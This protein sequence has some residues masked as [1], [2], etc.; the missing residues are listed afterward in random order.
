ME[1]K[2][3]A[4]R[5]AETM[6]SAL[7]K[8]MA[9]NI[10][11]KD[12]LK[13]FNTIL[14]EQA[15]WKA[16]LS[17]MEY[18]AAGPLDPAQFSKGIPLSERERLIQLGAQWH[19]AVERLIPA[20][21]AGFPKIRHELEELQ[22]AV[23]DGRF[24]PDFFLSAAFGGR[25]GEAQEIAGQIGLQAEVLK[26]VL[27]Q[28]AKPVV[29]RRAEILQALTKGFAWNKG[30]CPI[31]G[32]FPE[33]SL[34]REKEGQRWLR[35]GFCSSTWRFHRM[36]CPFCDAQEPGGLEIMFVEGREYERVEVCHQCKKYI[37]GI[38]LRSLANEVVLQVAGFTLMPLEAIA[39]KKGFLPMSGSRWNLL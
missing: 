32:S 39:Q 29:E 36:S 6:A 34:L 24:T 15:R 14:I 33:L 3:L 38:D 1:K 17:A 13:A 23:R 12:V 30:I 27:A 8:A 18:E 7:S 37:P 19:R 21:A 20:L 25:E 10:H 22:A 11:L 35:C 4:D 2:F 16:E 28:A 26:F 9:E 5:A 31:C